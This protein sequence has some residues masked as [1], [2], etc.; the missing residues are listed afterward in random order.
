VSDFRGPPAPKQCPIDNGVLDEDDYC[1]SCYEE[2][3]MAADL[4][5]WMRDGSEGDR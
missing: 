1:E 4:N 2:A 3:A 5:S